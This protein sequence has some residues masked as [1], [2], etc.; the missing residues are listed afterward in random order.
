MYSTFFGLE[1]VRRGLVA[2][3]TGMDVTGQNVANANTEGYSRQRALQ[4]AS[5]PYTVP[6]LGSPVMAGQL[7]TGVT[8]EQIQ[9][10]RDN[11]L[12]GQIRRETNSLGAWQAQNDALSQ[13]ETVFMEPSENGLNTLM[14]NFWSGW[15]ELSK[16]AEST[17][18]RTSLVQN[19]VSLTNGLNHIYSQMETVKEDLNQLLQIDVDDIN[20]KARQIADL[21]TQI[22]NI[23]ASGSQPNDLMDRRD[24]LLDEMSEMTNFTVTDLG[25]GS[26]QV[27]IG[28]QDGSAI[29]LVDGGSAY[30]L[31]LAD[32]SNVTDGALAGITQALSKLQGYED[33]L[34]ALAGELITQINTVHQ[35]GIDLSGNAGAV[36]F[37][38]SDA[39]DIAVSS[40]LSDD[41]TL[42]AAATTTDNPG[43]GSNALNIATLKSANCPGLGNTTLDNF[44]KNMIAKLGVD[45]QEST[46]MVE[47]QQALVDQL[48]NRKESISGVSMDEEMINLVQ[49]QYA[50]QGAARVVTILDSMLDTLINRM[51]V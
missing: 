46:R 22:T 48:V 9:R 13:V 31:A 1:T 41:V 21:N 34:N 10:I 7:G 44:Y 37:T 23:I 47:N 29:T 16:N 40:V 26:I 18:V 51:A 20:S 25:N 8:V 24:Q 19:A 28:F 2:A 5:D 4:V 49:Y 30:A 15:Q 27:N 14:A 42:V 6:S 45:T 12:D 36:F 17:P 50:Y 39:S 33:D 3:R 38:G 32:A 43:D 11:F 35:A